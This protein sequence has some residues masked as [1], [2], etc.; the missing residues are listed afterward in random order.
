MAKL[1]PEFNRDIC[2]HCGGCVGVCPEGALTLEETTVVVD[3]SKCVGCTKCKMFCP[4]GAI[5][6]TKK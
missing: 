4:V 6:M 3:E 5:T 2:L 1:I